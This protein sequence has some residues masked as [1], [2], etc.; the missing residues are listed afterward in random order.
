MR[1][2]AIMSAD[3]PDPEATIRFRDSDTG[4]ELQAGQRAFGRYLIEAELGRGGMGVVWRARDEKLG[5][6]VAL[7]FL[8]AAV[9]RDE[10]ALDELKEETRRARRLRHPN[11]VSVYYF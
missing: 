1:E 6:T 11:I 9:A 7:K 8:P 2:T 5:E 4:L 3:V 10:V